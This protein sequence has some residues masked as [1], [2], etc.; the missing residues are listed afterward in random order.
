MII[1]WGMTNIQ[2]IHDNYFVQNIKNYLYLENK[3]DVKTRP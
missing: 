3:Y 2:N 1:H